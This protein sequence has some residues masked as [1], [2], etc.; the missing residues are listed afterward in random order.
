MTKFTFILWLIAYGSC[1]G[2]QTSKPAQ[3]GGVDFF[4][5]EI[6][7]KVI[8]SSAVIS[9]IY[10]F[11][12]ESSAD[13]SIRI[14]FPFFVDSLSLF[15]HEI[16]PYLRNDGVSMTLPYRKAHN[17]IR[18]AIPFGDD[19]V[20]VWQ[21]D[22]VQR[23]KSQHVRYILAS[24]KTWHKPLQTATYKVE[25]PVGAS[26]VVIWPEPDSII[27]MNDTQIFW[28]HR[29]NFMPDRDLEIF[30]E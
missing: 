17:A 7:I 12:N 6:T 3:N 20:T 1:A 27:K 21:L 10:Y 11:R 15:P 14:L 25:M 18:F 16:Y 13:S 19:S 2:Q 24:T 28:S 30:W 5:E 26:N 29:E 23:I 4:K 9:G 8:D 22:Y